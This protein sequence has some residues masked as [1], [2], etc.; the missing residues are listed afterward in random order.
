MEQSPL[1]LAIQHHR[2]GRLADAEAIY[3]AVLAKNP[4][5]ADALNML[6][7]IARQT[8]HLPAAIDLISRA[9]RI[10]PDSADAYGNL[11]SALKEAGQWQA[12]AEAF[13]Q[14]IHLKADYA[15]LH[16]DLGE[17]L[18]RQGKGDEAIESYRRAAQYDPNLIDAHYSLGM[19]L[20]SKG[21]A[22]AALDAYRRV[23]ELD[24]NNADAHNNL[25]IALKDLGRVGEAVESYR[26]AIQLNPGIAEMHYNLG[27]AQR[28][29]GRLD[30]A[31]ESYRQAIQLKP[32]YSDAHSNLGLN[33]ADQGCLDEAITS[34]RRAIQLKPDNPFSHINLLYALYHH[35][36]VDSRTLLE[37]SR[38]WAR[39]LPPDSLP[40]SPPIDRAENRRLKIGYL[41]PFFGMCADAHFIYPLLANHD[42]AHF[43]IFCFSRAIREDEIAGR[44]RPFTDHWFDIRRLS[45]DAAG[46]LIRDQK[47][48]I[49]VLMS[50]PADGCQTI[51]ARRLAPIQI[52]WL[53][54]ASA[55]TGLQSFDY[56][57]SDPF[58]DPP[59]MDES[60]YAEK[61]VRLPATAWSYDPLVDSPPVNSLPVLNN[62]YITFGSFN[63]ISKINSAVVETWARIMHAVQKS[64]LNILAIPGSHRQRL[65]DQF[66]HAR[67][68]PGRIEFFDR[69]SRF[70]YLQQ[71]HRID[72]TLD[73]FPFVGHTTAMDSLW[74]G[75]PIVTLAG[76]TCVGGPAASALQ[77]LGL[78]HLIAKTQDQLVSIATGLARDSANLANLRAG[79]RQKMQVSPLTDA[80]QFAQEM[81]KIYHQVW[82]QLPKS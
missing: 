23:I 24:P 34:C 43:E 10:R 38:Q 64:R 7:V 65:L 41:S 13:R 33:L 77:N 5:D 63:R 21:D 47:L 67:I 3:R 72:I 80:R 22:A 30:D 37:E 29:Q 28:I 76:R 54:F 39:S 62:G 6:G 31:T 52:N 17:V 25:A 27:N 82:D 71:Y 26:R 68:D 15:K 69:Q 12:A 57:I 48:D 20:I 11:G 61:I 73:A 14:A 4:N 42:R 70:E 9:T 59:Q 60:A 32:D 46:D 53:T 19:A 79:L 8:G 18:N 66:R 2:A 49:L 75:V 1:L 56:R 16:F 44:M 78:S 50:Q 81:Q 58:I 40:Y 36:D 55:T 74:M 45:T 35:P 51:A